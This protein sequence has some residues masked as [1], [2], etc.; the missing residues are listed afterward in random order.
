M[1]KDSTANSGSPEPP[2]ALRRER[3][4]GRTEAGHGVRVRLEKPGEATGVCILA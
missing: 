1:H 4:G 3:R 2:A